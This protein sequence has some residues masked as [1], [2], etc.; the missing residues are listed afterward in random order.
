MIES[1]VVIYHDEGIQADKRGH[2]HVLLFVPVKVVIKETGGLLE[3][4]TREF[5]PQIELFK[6]I[7]EIRDKRE[8]DHKFHFS[9]ISG[10]KWSKRN[11]A[12]RELVQIGIEYLKQKETFCKL[13]I[14]FF[15]NPKPN[16]IENYGGNN[17]TEK[18]LRFEETILRILLKGTVHYLY[19]TNHKVKILKIITDGQPHH[20]RLSEFRILDRLINEVRDYV[21]I[22]PDAEI[23]HLPSNHRKYNKASEEYIHANLL[24]LADM[25]LGC[26]IYFCLRDTKV[27]EEDKKWKIGASVKE[28][29]D[30]QKRGRG[31]KNSSHYKA[32][33]IS[34]AHLKNTGWEFENVMPKKFE[35]SNTGQLSIL[36]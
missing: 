13:G 27:S 34:K 3:P 22:S 19:D 23:V 20:R 26:S 7:K 33:T 24:Q 2:G 16:Q 12:E 32:F 4:Q 14:I 28:M 17:K 1:E 30:K 15:E 10:K 11:D 31:F 36:D 9:G 8:V 21:E 5:K 35:I 18:K 25:L 29:L 6:K